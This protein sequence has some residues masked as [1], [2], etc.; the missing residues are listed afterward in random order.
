M[1]VHNVFDAIDEVTALQISESFAWIIDTCQQ[2][3]VVVVVG[4]FCKYLIW[5]HAKFNLIVLNQH[6]RYQIQAIILNQKKNFVFLS[7]CLEN[8]RGEQ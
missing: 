7:K 5:K 2:P 3:T 4:V 6:E 1:D 8:H